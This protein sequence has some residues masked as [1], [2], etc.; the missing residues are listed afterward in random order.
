MVVEICLLQLQTPSTDL[1]TLV[2]KEEVDNSCI[3]KSFMSVDLV[4]FPIRPLLY[5]IVV[6]NGRTDI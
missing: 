2:Y 4:R 3:D 6:R 5:K 1:S